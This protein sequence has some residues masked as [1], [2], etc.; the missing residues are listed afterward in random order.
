MLF[1]RVRETSNILFKTQRIGQND[2]ADGKVPILYV[3]VKHLN[4]DQGKVSLQ[5]YEYLTK[6]LYESRWKIKSNRRWRNRATI[7]KAYSSS[8]FLN[9]RQVMATKSR[10]EITPLKISVLH[11]F[12]SRE[13]KRK[14][15][16]I[17]EDL[18]TLAK[19]LELLEI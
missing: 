6:N 8:I 13:R 2:G 11:K 4:R 10:K 5:G 9:Q 1:C 19:Q 3:K 17:W 7:Q 16:Q 14:L 18:L 15:G 12:N